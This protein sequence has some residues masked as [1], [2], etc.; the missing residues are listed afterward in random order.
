MSVRSNVSGS[1]RTNFICATDTNTTKRKKPFE[2]RFDKLGTR[3]SDLIE[4]AFHKKP[5]LPD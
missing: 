5:A 4:V 2:S 1:V 3:T